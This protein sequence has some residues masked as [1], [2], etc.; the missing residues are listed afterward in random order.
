[1]PHSAKLFLANAMYAM[2]SR[3]GGFKELDGNIDF[4]DTTTT[5]VALYPNIVT[6][7]FKNV[8]VI[9]SLQPG[10]H[11]AGIFVDP[12]STHDVN[13]VYRVDKSLFY[14]NLSLKLQ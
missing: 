14:Q 10:N 2:V 3:Q 8:P 11:Y 4:W 12:Q 5:F 6:T 9:L 1:M 13:V 7:E